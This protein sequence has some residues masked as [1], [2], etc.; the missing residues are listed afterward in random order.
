MKNNRGF[1]IIELIVVLVVIG[2]VAGV[3]LPRYAGSL[4]SLNFK[5]KMSDI[6]FFFREARIKAISTAG[7]TYVALDLHNG[8]FWNE[9]KRVLQL[10][11]E[12]QIFTNKIEARNEK[13]KTFEFYPNGTA[14]EEIVGFVCDKTIAILHVEPLGGL[15]YFRMN[16][17]MDQIVRY[18]R[19]SDVLSEEEILQRIPVDKKENFDTLAEVVSDEET[20]DNDFYEDDTLYE[21]KEF[22][23]E[24]R[25]NE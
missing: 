4:E 9:D 15:V 3:A 6:V 22:S 2:I 24:E 10:P 11:P 21:E 7:T 1:T 13:T 23:Y 12:I 5:K 17:E 18:A 16:E 20:L 14:Q 19:N 8:Y 25:G